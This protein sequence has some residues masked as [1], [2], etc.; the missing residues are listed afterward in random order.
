MN[1]QNTNEGQTF[2]SQYIMDML[3][4]VIRQ[5]ISYYVGE[6]SHKQE[7]IGNF[8]IG[9]VIFDFYAG[10]PGSCGRPY[11][12]LGDYIDT[13]ALCNKVKKAYERDFPGQACNWSVDEVEGFLDANGEGDHINDVTSLLAKL[14]FLKR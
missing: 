14:Y 8:I 4:K 13:R 5:K 3:K 11:G 2:N 9:G 12:H 6:G 10:M 7:G 1:T